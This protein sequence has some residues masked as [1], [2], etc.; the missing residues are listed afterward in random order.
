MSKFSGKRVVITG[1]GR[2]IG[3]AIAHAFAREGAKLAIISRNPTSC[4][5]A[6]KE[7]NAVHP[8][9]TRFYPLD[10]ADFDSVQ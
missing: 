5:A 7:I 9:S 2:G 6:A 8:D 3:L 1:A 4:G 10:V